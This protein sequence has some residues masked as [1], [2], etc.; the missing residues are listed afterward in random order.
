M[1]GWAVIALTLT[2]FAVVSGRGDSGWEDLVAIL[3]IMLFGIALLALAAIAGVARLLMSGSTAR[4]VTLLVGPP[5]LL[6]VLVFGLQA[7]A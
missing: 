5:I 3:I 6:V 1:G 2:V 7:I 4:T